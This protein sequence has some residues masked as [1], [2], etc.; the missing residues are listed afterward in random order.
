MRCPRGHGELEALYLEDARTHACRTCRGE[1]ITVGLLRRM[2]PKERLRE[3]WARVRSAP[4]GT[5]PCPSCSRPMHLVVVRGGPE[6]LSIDGCA[7]CQSVWFDPG[8]LLAVAPGAA[9]PAPVVDAPMP[10]RQEREIWDEFFRKLN[11]RR[12]RARRVLRHL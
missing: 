11:E 7:P 1:T 5:A 6:P 8:E 12:D 10:E 2:M 4:A 3:L 9:A